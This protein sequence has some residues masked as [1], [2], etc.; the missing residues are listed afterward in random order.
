LKEDFY[1][2]R[3]PTLQATYICGLETAYI[4][5]RIRI[6]FLD[7]SKK[8]VS[9]AIIVFC[10]FP[11]QPSIVV[12]ELLLLSTNYS[13]PPSARPLSRGISLVGRA[14]EKSFP[15]STTTDLSHA[16]HLGNGS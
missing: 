7:D 5:A 6:C 11:Q 3:T 4:S 14:Q 1:K 10:I 2:A 8:S 9:R 15:L 16:S 12:K 13:A